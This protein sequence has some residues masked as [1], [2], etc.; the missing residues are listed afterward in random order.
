MTAVPSGATSHSRTMT[1]PVRS[2]ISGVPVTRICSAAGLDQL[3]K[4]SS[5]AS[6]W[7]GFLGARVN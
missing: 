4:L 7:C 1:L 6:A 2:V 5:D 3:Q